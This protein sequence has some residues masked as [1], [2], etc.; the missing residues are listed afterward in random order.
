MGRRGPIEGSRFSGSFRIGLFRGRQ[1]RPFGN[2]F[3]VEIRVVEPQM[4]GSLQTCFDQ[5]HM[6][7]TQTRGQD[8]LDD[9]NGERIVWAGEYRPPHDVG[10]CDGWNQ[11][12][13][14]AID[15][16]VVTMT[17]FNGTQI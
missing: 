7:G 16:E 4:D 11:G 2:H 15:T 9:G 14:I 17:G 8:A 1:D 5:D 13:T 10:K 6:L 3:E 12:D